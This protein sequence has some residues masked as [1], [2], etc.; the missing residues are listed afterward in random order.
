M[1][2]NVR[3]MLRAEGIFFGATPY[4]KDLNPRICPNCGH[5]FEID[6][7]KQVFD[8][9]Q[10]KSLLEGNGFR[11]LLVRHFSPD[12]HY[13]GRSFLDRLFDRIS[14]RDLVTQLEFIA[15]PKR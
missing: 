4:K 7:H 14:N 2:S 11:A 1:S 8:D 13:L 12:H 9:E 15:V 6:H 10:M 3:T 5:V